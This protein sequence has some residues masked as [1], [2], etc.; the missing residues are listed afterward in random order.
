M[1]IIS[2]IDEDTCQAAQELL[3]DC[4]SVVANDPNSNVYIVCVHEPVE[5]DHTKG[6]DCWC[7]PVKM[8][9]GVQ[10]FFSEA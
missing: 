9:F 5:G 8:V 2:I 10:S 3:D 6:E 1:P 7:S 4:V